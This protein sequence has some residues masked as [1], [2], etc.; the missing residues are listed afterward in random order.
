[1]LGRRSTF[2]RIDGAQQRTY[3]ALNRIIQPSAADIFKTKLVEVYRHRKQFDFVMRLVVHDELGGD[4][5]DPSK[6]VAFTAFLNEQIVPIR[7]PI[8]WDGGTGANWH[9]AKEG[10]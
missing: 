5:C 10:E 2:P 1:V 6:E 4:L 7:V 3:A 8:L 9:D